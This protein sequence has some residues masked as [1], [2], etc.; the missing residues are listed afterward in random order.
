[1]TLTSCCS[2]TM[3]PF[4]FYKQQIFRLQTKKKNPA[5]ILW[6]FFDPYPE[7]LRSLKVKYHW[8][9]H[10]TLLSV[11]CLGDIWGRRSDQ[12]I[13]YVQLILQFF[14]PFLGYQKIIFSKYYKV[15]NNK[16]ISLYMLR[17]YRNLKK[18]GLGKRV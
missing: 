2:L 14:K 9:G 13:H 16:L 6:L 11:K 7:I 12:G 5:F 15:A 4:L 10:I 18:L 17:T 3:L 1:M 8:N